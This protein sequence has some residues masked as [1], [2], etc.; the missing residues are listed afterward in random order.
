M[1]RITGTNQDDALIGTSRVDQ[2]LGFEGQ[3]TLDGGFG[4]DHLIGGP[5]DDTY[6]FDGSD[7]LFEHARGGVDTAIT[8]VSYALPQNFEK[9]VLSGTGDIDG[10]G[11]SGDNVIVG[12]PGS[13]V[14]SGGDGND[15]LDGG[16]TGFNVFGAD[17]LL[18]GAGDDILIY[19][20]DDQWNVLETF[21]FDGGAGTDTLRVVT[22]GQVFQLDSAIQNIEVI[23]L[24]AA[25]N[26]V[27]FLNGTTV[28]QVSST[29]DLLRIEGGADDRIYAVSDNYWRFSGNVSIEGETYEE[30]VH[31]GASATLHIDEDVDVQLADALA[32]PPAPVQSSDA[33]S[34]DAEVLQLTDV[35]SL[36][37]DAL[38]GNET[39]IANTLAAGVQNIPSGAGIDH[40]MPAPS[41]TTLLVEPDVNPAV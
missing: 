7:R 19:D 14:L 38:A 10:T 30:Y 16:T 22:D 13:N 2:V 31:L 27:L 39:G 23:D 28:E 34:I 21:G 24:A 17:L 4:R 18:G 15:Y 25:E 6:L 36:D 37:T 41:L 20:P 26:N 3:D 40:P 29:T 8:H 35:L 33:G 5:G 12:N 9:L 1:A 32:P 11:N